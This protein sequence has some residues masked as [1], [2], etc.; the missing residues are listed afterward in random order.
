MDIDICIYMHIYVIYGIYLQYVCSGYIYDLCVC[1]FVC[2]EIVSNIYQ[3]LVHF[4]ISATLLT[5]TEA[6]LHPY[7]FLFIF[8]LCFG[9]SQVLAT[10]GE[11]YYSFVV[12]IYIAL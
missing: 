2:S 7:F 1:V 9:F 10:H 11:L 12:Y 4:V 6:L 8:P 3:E 5:G